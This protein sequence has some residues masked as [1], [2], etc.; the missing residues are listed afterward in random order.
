V[1]L[2]N[3]CGLLPERIICVRIKESS[4]CFVLQGQRSPVFRIAAG[5]ADAGSC[6][7]NLLGGRVIAWQRQTLCAT[8]MAP[9]ETLDLREPPCRCNLEYRFAYADESR[10]TDRDKL[11]CASNQPR[12]IFFLGRERRFVLL[13]NRSFAQQT[14]PASSI[15]IVTGKLRSAMP[16]ES[17]PNGAG[18]SAHLQKGSFYRSEVTKS[19][20][21]RLNLSGPF[22]LRPSIIICDHAKGTLE[23]TNCRLALWLVLRLLPSVGPR[24]GKSMSSA[25]PLACFQRPAVAKSP[26]L[27]GS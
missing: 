6:P 1:R 18:L 25:R 7:D 13:R 21:C 22:K 8:V 27:A 16:L 2:I 4:F 24:V 3:R 10:S 9:G 17:A 15:L 11:C 14:D 20:F 26:V 5:K 19:G 12:D 23:I